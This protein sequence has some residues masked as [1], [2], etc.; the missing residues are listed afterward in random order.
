M[1]D[2]LTKL[3]NLEA[4]LMDLELPG[5]NFGEDD[6]KMIE[7]TN[8]QIYDL[9]RRFESNEEIHRK[10]MYYIRGVGLNRKIHFGDES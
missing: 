4:E 7:K 1:Q 2:K 5:V 6:V 10:E 9:M 8:R 3:M